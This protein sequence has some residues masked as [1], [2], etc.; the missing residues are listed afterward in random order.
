[1]EAYRR[2]RRRP[3]VVRYRPDSIKNLLENVWKL[4][5]VAIDLSF[6]AYFARDLDIAMKIL[7]L[8]KTIGEN[9][10]QFVMHNAMAFG[11]SKK[12]GY[13]ALLSYYYGSSIDM[14]SDSVKDIVNALLLGH[15]TKITYNQFLSYAEGEVV[16]K[17]LA[18]R[19]MYAVDLTDAYPIDILA[20]VGDGE[21]RFMPKRDELIK[22]GST[23][24]LRGFR[25]NVLRLLSE[26]GVECSLETI[27]QPELEHLVKSLVEI[28]DYTML[29]LDLAHYVLM[30]LSSELMEEIGDLE[31]SLNLKQTE[32]VNLLKGAA[33]KIDS[34]TFI[35]LVR[36]LRELENIAEASDNISY[37]PTLQE[38]LPSIY[39]ELFS[40]VFESVGEKVRTI[41]VSRQ[42]NLS[43]IDYYLRKYGG[44]VLAVKK[45]AFWI[46][47][48]FAR[49][50]TLAPDDKMII[51]Y[52]QEFSE[53]VEGLLKSRA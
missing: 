47:Y 9:V 42:L 38:E 43:A 48:P 15:T 23:L 12:G 39:K 32:A 37:I 44:N 4:T 35:G 20:V 53:E 16:A 5:N 33:A 10:G 3:P 6:Y 11:R 19:D 34:E 1:M 14:I 25:E 50:I 45:G 40:K 29:I 7:D 26:F 46:A 17:M 18:P 27:G 2:L 22:R 28:K 51:V 41:T 52:P 21:V 13:A 49:E 31:A 36:L 24:Y 30:D 8:D